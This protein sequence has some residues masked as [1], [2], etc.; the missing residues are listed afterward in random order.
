MRRQ[1]RPTPTCRTPDKARSADV[2]HPGE[3]STVAAEILSGANSA[4]RQDVKRPVSSPRSDDLPRGMMWD[5][6]V[7]A[8]VSGATRALS[9]GY[10]APLACSQTVP[11]RPQTRHLRVG[12]SWCK[13]TTNRVGATIDIRPDCRRKPRIGAWR[14]R[15]VLVFL[16]PV[17]RCGRAGIASQVG[18]GWERTSMMMAAS[19]VARWIVRPSSACCKIFVVVVYKTDASLPS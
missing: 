9:D 15:D 8:L 18:L 3:P 5:W 13:R 17:S 11:F 6:L 10:S 16:T 2:V 14:E 4:P 1:P 19:R 12:G 7:S